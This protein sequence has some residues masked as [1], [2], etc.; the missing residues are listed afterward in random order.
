MKFNDH[1]LRTITSALTCAAHVF[2]TDAKDCR[3]RPTADP[4]RVGFDRLA[5]QF[6]RQ[7]RTA[8]DLLA[9]IEKEEAGSI[10]EGAPPEMS[11]DEIRRL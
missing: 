2:V 6:D 7:A 1:E 3:E 11:P 5:D 10:E 4:E 8:L 9:R